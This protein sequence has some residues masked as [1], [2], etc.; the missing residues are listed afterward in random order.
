M[1]EL[2]YNIEMPAIG[3]AYHIQ[4]HVS[5]FEGKQYLLKVI[6]WQT[7]CKQ[8]NDDIHHT[9][10]EVW[11]DGDDLL[12]MLKKVHKFIGSLS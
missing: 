2:D 10:Y 12:D 7:Y 4:V 6:Q 3:N 1:E 5:G 8:L 9:M 11:F